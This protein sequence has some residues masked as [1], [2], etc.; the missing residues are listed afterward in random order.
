MNL[1]LMMERIIVIFEKIKKKFEIKKE[2]NIN[3]LQ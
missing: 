3:L 2:K 1:F